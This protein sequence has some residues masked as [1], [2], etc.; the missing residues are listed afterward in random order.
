MKLETNNLLNI[1]IMDGLP[2]SSYNSYKLS[3]VVRCFGPSVV[4]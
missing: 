2:M 4:L 3:K 1:D